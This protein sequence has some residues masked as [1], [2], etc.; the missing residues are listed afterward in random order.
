[1]GSFNGKPFVLEDGWISSYS[2]PFYTDAA[3]SIGY[4][5]IFGKHWAYGTWPDSWKDN[6]VSFLEFFSIVLGLQLWCSKLKNKQALF[7]TDNKSIVYIINK[8]TTKDPKLLSLLRTPVLICRSARNILADR[9]RL[10][11]QGPIF[12][13]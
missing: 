11:I 5:L 2:L 8:Q 13:I 7:M 6:H 10:Q 12:P 4:G 3:Q 9:D 1:M